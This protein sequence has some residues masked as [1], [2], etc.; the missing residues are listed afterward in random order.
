[1]FALHISST[2]L[3]W[4]EVMGWVT[5]CHKPMSCKWK[6]PVMVY[7]DPHPIFAS[8]LL[9]QAGLQHYLVFEW[10]VLPCSSWQCCC[11]WPPS[12]ALHPATHRSESSSGLGIG[13]CCNHSGKN[14]RE[15]HCGPREPGAHQEFHLRPRNKFFSLFPWLFP[16]QSMEKSLLDR[17][18]F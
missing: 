15:H 12:L 13:W 9:S 5:W 18:S 14:S 4:K 1:M 6:T 3:P 7:G 10:P 17:L 8:T 11:H 2:S 16:S